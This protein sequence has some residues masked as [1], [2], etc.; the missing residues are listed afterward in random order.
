MKKFIKD[1]YNEHGGL[2]IVFGIV[3]TIWLSPLL[4]TFIGLKFA[5][6]MPINYLFKKITTNR[7]F[8]K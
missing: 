7:P 1:L 6:V 8:K 4:L 5:I 3:S 2:A